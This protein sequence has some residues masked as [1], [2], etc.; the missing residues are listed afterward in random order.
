MIDAEPFGQKPVLRHD[1]VVVVVVGKPGAKAVAGL[2]RLAVPNVVGKDDEV[3]GRV[4]EL[5]GTKEDTAKL[6][7]EK[8][9]SAAPRAV[10]DQYCIP[11]YPSRI[12]AGR[13]ERAVMKLQFGQFLTALKAK[14]ANCEISFDGNW[15]LRRGGEGARAHQN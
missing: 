13:P 8:A 12:P 7:G 4:Q 9:A 15:L 6:R 5:P 3:P 1:H 10:E 11:H 14:A 2:A